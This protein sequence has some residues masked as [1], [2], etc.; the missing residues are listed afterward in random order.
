MIFLIYNLFYLLSGTQ[1]SN[2]VN[3]THSLFWKNT[4]NNKIKVVSV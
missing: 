3:M 1:T 4:I 2:Q